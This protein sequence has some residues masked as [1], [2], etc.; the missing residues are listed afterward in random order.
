MSQQE[1]ILDQSAI[2]SADFKFD[3]LLGGIKAAMSG[4]SPATSG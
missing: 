3:L 2:P 4:P 1:T